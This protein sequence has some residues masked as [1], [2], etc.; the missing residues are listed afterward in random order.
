MPA[1]VVDYVLVHELAHLLEIGHDAKFW[2]WV[3]LPGGRTGA[4]YL[5]G[6]SAAAQLDPPQSEGPAEIDEPV[7][8]D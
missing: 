2:A 6:W 3:A 4:G 7:E 5:L 1:W 8:I